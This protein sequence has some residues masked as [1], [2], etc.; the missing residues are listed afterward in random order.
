MGVYTPYSPNE[1]A[2]ARQ[3]DMTAELRADATAKGEKK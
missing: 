2:A 3:L 1:Q